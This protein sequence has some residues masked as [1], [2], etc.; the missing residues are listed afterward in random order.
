MNCPAQPDLTISNFQGRQLILKIRPIPLDKVLSDVDDQFNVNNLCS[1][2][3][4]EEVLE[5]GRTKHWIDL[6]HP[7]QYQTLI[8]DYQDLAWMRRAAHIGE[9][10]GRFPAYL[11]EEEMAETVQKYQEQ[12]DGI[13]T[14]DPELQ[15]VRSDKVSLK[16]GQHGVGP[17]RS[18]RSLLE[19]ATS[20]IA[21]HHPFRLIGPVNPEERKEEKLTFYL[22]KWR[23]I[24]PLKEFRIFVYQ[25]QITAISQQHLEQEN[26]WLESLSGLEIAEQ[27]V[28]P[29]L[30]YFNGH[31][32][33]RMASIGST[34]YV[35][36][37]ALLENGTPYFIEP[38]SFGAGYAAGS[39]L[40]HWLADQSLLEGRITNDQGIRIIELRFTS[41]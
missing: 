39:A 2:D 10:L 28:Q 26:S 3:D 20:S 7:D 6:F 31:V 36:D 8:L 35:M 14:Q 12:F 37:L 24:D 18:L 9:M 1:V 33:P 19:S 5:K 32:A 41:D 27:V 13:Q 29:I 17:Y 25:Q 34:D 4:Y 15:F 30:E 21:G 16:Y 11:L 23:Q 22:M 40:F 38:N